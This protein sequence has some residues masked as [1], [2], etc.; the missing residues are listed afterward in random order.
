MGVI[1]FT[2]FA[3][4]SIYRKHNCSQMFKYIIAVSVLSALALAQDS[5]NLDYAVLDVDAYHPDSEQWTQNE[6]FD[7][8]RQAY[9]ITDCDRYCE[10][11]TE[12]NTCDPITEKWC[13]TLPVDPDMHHCRGDDV[14]VPIDCL[15]KH[16]DE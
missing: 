11:C 5:Q 4:F 13:K 14:C 2:L 12:P 15:C 6:G 16:H 7:H 9:C 10:N 3:N 8:F 1:L